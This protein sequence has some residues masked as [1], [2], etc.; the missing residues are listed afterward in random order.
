[1]LLPDGFPGQRLYVLPTPLVDEA[2][3]R[4]PTSRLLVTDAGHFPRAARHGRHRPEG[5]RQTIVILCVAGLGWVEMDG[6]RQPVPAGHVTV[7]PAGT[8]HRYHADADDPWTIWW[9]HV[10]GTDVSDLVGATALTVGSAV[11]PLSDPDHAERLLEEVVDHLETDETYASL[12]RAAGAAWNLLAVVVADQADGSGDP[13]PVHR[14]QDLLRA[15]LARRIGVGELARSVGLSTSHLTTRFREVTGFSL[16]EYVKRL[17]MAR[18]RQL[19]I[20]TSLSVAQI[21]VAVGYPDAF[22][23]SRQFRVVHGTSPREFRRS[24]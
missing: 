24:G 4:A 23:F 17:R 2:L 10:T 11:A 8:A 5:A 1:M 6:L 20:T 22:Y 15:D 7:L 21:G 19:L 3:R 13:E 9:V 14:A 12:V 18:A 16:T